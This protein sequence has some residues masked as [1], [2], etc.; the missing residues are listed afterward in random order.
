MPSWAGLGQACTKACRWRGLP[1]AWPRTGAGAV[2][3]CDNAPTLAIEREAPRERMFLIVAVYEIG[4][5]GKAP[6]GPC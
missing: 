5:A 6:K 4:G 2:S 3:S 1:I